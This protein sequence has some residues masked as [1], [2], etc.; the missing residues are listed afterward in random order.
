MNEKIIKLGDA[1]MALTTTEAVELQ[2]YLE[3]KGLVMVQQA[4]T[5]VQAVTVEE[6]TESENVNLVVITA[7]GSKIKFAKALIYFIIGLS[8]LLI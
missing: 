3:S 5:T 8:L 1:L 6:V 7:S 4:P 2:T